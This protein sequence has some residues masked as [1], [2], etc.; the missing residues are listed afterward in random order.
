MATVI[1][2]LGLSGIIGYPL[3]VK[4]CTQELDYASDSLLLFMKYIIEIGSI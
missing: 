4:A 1:R 2:S 3:E